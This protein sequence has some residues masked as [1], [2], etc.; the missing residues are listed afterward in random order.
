MN[1]LSILQV[2]SKDLSSSN[3]TKFKED[4]GLFGL[5]FKRPAVRVRSIPQMGSRVGLAG[6]LS[7]GIEVYKV[8][9]SCLALV[10]SQNPQG[11]PA[12]AMEGLCRWL[13]KR[14]FE[15]E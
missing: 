13:R 7:M 9:C 5:W 4:L 12:R 14:W 8:A 1:L 10:C 6:L 15:H 3:W 2:L 11:R